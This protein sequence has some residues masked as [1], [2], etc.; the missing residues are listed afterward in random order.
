[1]KEK[2]HKKPASTASPLRFAPLIR[3]STEAQEKRGESLRVQKAQY[4]D[5]LKVLG[6]V[7]PEDCWKYCG[8][9]HATPDYERKKLDLFLQDAGKDLYDAVWVY[10][11]SRWSRDNLKSEEGLRILMESDKKFF[12]R[13]TE[14]DLHSPQ[15]RLFLA[16]FTVMNQYLAAEQARKS[17]N[18]KIKRAE[19]NRPAFGRLPWGRTYNKETETWGLD[20][21]LK[22]QMIIAGERYL[23]GD[24]MEKIAATMLFKVKVKDGFKYKHLCTATLCRVLTRFSGDTWVVTNNN[25]KL[26]TYKTFTFKVDPLLPQDM[27]DAILEKVAANKTYTHGQTKNPYMLGRMIFCGECGA[28]LSGQ[29]NSDGRLWYRHPYRSNCKVRAGI[30]AG[31]IEMAVPVHLFSMYGDVKA[32]EKAVENAFPNLDEFRHLE[33]QIPVLETGISKARKEKERIIDKIAKGIISDD[34]AKRKMQELREREAMLTGEVTKVK[35]KISSIPSRE[36][37]RKYTDTLMEIHKE[38]INI[39][40][41]RYD[42][43]KT[44]TYEDKRALMQTVFAGKDMEGHRYGVYMKEKGGEWCFEMRGKLI[45]F[46]GLYPVNR[47]WEKLIDEKFLPNVDLY[48]EDFITQGVIKKEVLICQRKRHQII[49]RTFMLN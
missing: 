48:P 36:S 45:P 41:K 18:S 2:P 32:M 17:L 1:M 43:F 11:P 10:D 13:T 28:A 5:D 46:G 34:D 49:P 29:K 8:Q 47:D 23:R 33:S 30:P 9:E 38:L 21:E 4:E 12:V 39:K 31:P 3:V 42:H 37:I 40:F 27:I 7:S 14:Y 19:R 22:N 24:G 26:K 6:A 16:M 20:E 15:D 44:M 35:E 25:K